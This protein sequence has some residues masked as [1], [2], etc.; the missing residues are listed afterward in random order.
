MTFAVEAIS[1]KDLG[2]RDAQD[3]EIFQSAK[4]EGSVIIT[5]DSDF[6]ELVTRFGTPPQILWITCGNVTNRN[7]KKLL[8]N[9]FP[10]ALQLLQ[11]GEKVVEISE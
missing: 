5:K 2:L 10:Q 3:S 4:I 11:K 1:L 6:I 8:T 9:T 7:L